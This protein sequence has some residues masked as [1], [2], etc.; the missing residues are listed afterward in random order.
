MSGLVP[1][2]QDPWCTLYH[3]AAEAVIPLLPQQIDVVL[4][5]PPYG[6]LETHAKHLSTVRLRHGEP[7]RQVLPFAGIS[8]DALVAL[9]TCLVQ[10]AR[11]WVIFSCEWKHA[12]L[13]DQAGL[14]VRLGI[15]RK[16]N[17]APQFTGDRPGM[18]WEAI[19]IC[20]RPGA[21]RWNGGGKH[22]FWDFPTMPETGHPTAKPV[23][24]YA[25]LLRDF[26][27]PNEVVL[28]PFMGSGTVLVASK[29]LGRTSIGIE[30]EERYCEMAARRLA[31]EVLPLHSAPR[32]V[33]IPQA[34]LFG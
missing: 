12:H 14:L 26:S 2:Y 20:H 23:A 24:L 30:I 32:P 18:G 25:E 4:T 17:G 8:A 31:Q 29:N 15:W 21:K 5:D 27:D 19:A 34:T 13:L 9:A 1:Y 16:R 6:A 3:G 10:T 22:A 7:A 28:D 33:P 11:R